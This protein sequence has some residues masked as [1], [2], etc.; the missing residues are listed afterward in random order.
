MSPDPSP[1]RAFEV[2]QRRDLIGKSTLYINWGLWDASTPDIDSAARALVLHV[3]K[4]AQVGPGTRLLDVG[5]GYADQLLDWCRLADLGFAEGLNICPEQTAIARARIAEA[6]LSDRVKVQVGD[7]VC[8][9]FPHEHFTAVTAIECAFHFRTREQFFRESA[10]VLQPRGNLVLADFIG[11]DRP[12]RR[13]KLAQR[14]AAKHWGFAPGSFCSEATYREM[15]ERTGFT[16]RSLERVTER[17]IPH[18]MRYARARI[19]DRDLR[20]RMRHSTWLM[21]TAALGLSRALRDPSP[22][23]YIIVHAQRQP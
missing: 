13:Q 5:F 17:V 14:L 21:T 11:L 1:Q 6:G 16:I 3:G 10:R 23:E 9:P 8:L 18:G 12:G 4:L 20:N 19:W 15:L 2:Y 22:G 7:A